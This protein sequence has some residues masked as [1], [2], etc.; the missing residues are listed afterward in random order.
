[1]E[2]NSQRDHLKLKEYGR[3]IQ[4]LVDH[5]LSL[6]DIKEKQD[7]V[8][9]IIGIMGNLNPHLKNVDD[10][11]HLLW[12]HLHIISD[13]QLTD[14]ESPYPM[15]E[16]E[17]LFAKPEIFPY[18]NR[19]KRF[20]HYG[21]HII[22][23]IEKAVVM[24]DLEKKAGYTECI[25]NYMKIVYS[26]YNRENVSDE[27]IR[28]ELDVI[29]QG[30]LSLAP[31]VVLQKVQASSKHPKDNNNSSKG[32]HKNKKRYSNQKRNKNYSKSR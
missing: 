7:V 3:N 13:F 28:N 29:S 6:T 32:S 17:V 11:N 14:I 2:Y 4:K 21:K 20:R 1:M 12:D 24:E 30:R 26:N 27:I 10:F 31:D 16:K 18:P 25:A 9:Q 23:M 8:D 19:N 15:P 22:A 5:A